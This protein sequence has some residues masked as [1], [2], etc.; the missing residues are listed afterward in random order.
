MADAQ[1][2]GQQRHFALID[3]DEA[4]R[5]T[6]LTATPLGRE[7]LPLKKAAGRVLA[8]PVIAR[9]G[10]PRQDVSAMDGYAVRDVDTREIPFSLPVNGEMFAGS[11]PSLALRPGTACRIFTGAP[12][13][14]HA[15]RVIVQEN[16]EREGDIAH[17]VRPFGP[18]RHIRKAGSDFSESDVLLPSGHRLD[19]RSMTTAAAADRAQVDVFRVPRLVILATGDE[20]A[21]P[22]HAH[23]RAGAIP[24]SV[25]FG[26]QA[27]ARNRSADV[28]RSL[29]LT[30]DPAVLVAA[31]SAALSD[32]DLTIVI[33]GA[34]VGE[35]DYS[36]QIFGERLE[37]VFPKVA[38][39]P[40]KP[41]WLARAGARLVLGLPGN[42]TSALVTARL[43]L[44]PLLT[45]LSGGDPS[46]AVTFRNSACLDALPAT[47]DRETFLRGRLTETGV[48][49]AFSQDS[50]SQM[51]L[52]FSDVL[53]RR[54]AGAQAMP[55]G[56]AVPV[57][58]F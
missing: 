11:D 13:P 39:K 10:M 1:A 58:D 51:S 12:V 45:G 30:D 54:P 32:A 52:A 43:F 49:L 9:A 35:K 33:G 21:A 48:S 41:V 25:A 40:G 46:K 20:L 15:D 42:P 18:G 17:F 24:E 29:R 2:T 38:I 31:A 55:P 36:R 28:L 14:A 27:F 53:I 26:I 56:A 4:L 8:A 16:V 6:L 47:G 50:S 37:Y 7:S 57:L 3:F 22:G 19:W 34:S 44:A 23:E 5:R